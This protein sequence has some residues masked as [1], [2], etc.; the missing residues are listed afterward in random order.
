VY[1]RNYIWKNTWDKFFDSKHSL[2]EIELWSNE[3]GHEIYRW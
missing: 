3:I 2:K 1:I